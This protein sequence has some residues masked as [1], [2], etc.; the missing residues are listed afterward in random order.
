MDA[1]DGHQKQLEAIGDDV[2]MSD[3]A[4][5]KKTCRNPFTRQ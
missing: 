3:D 2:L 4:I 5:A 1:L